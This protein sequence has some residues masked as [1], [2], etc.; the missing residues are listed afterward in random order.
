MQVRGE[1][2]AFA[3]R[4]LKFDGRIPARVHLHGELLGL[5]S[6]L[7]S[8]GVKQGIWFDLDTM[9]PLMG[10]PAFKQA[11]TVFVELASLMP[12]TEDKATCMT[13]NTPFLTGQCAMTISWSY[14]FKVTPRHAG[15]HALALGTLDIPAHH[16]TCQIMSGHTSAEPTASF[17]L[18]S[19]RTKSCQAV[20]WTPGQHATCYSVAPDC[21]RSC[22]ASSTA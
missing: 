13:Y 9:L 7:Q 4:G 11:M 12:P 16:A 10:T 22:L 5:A 1:S 17:H 6:H 15:H 21:G 20:L 2:V 18:L 19:N 3:Q 14:Y 8:Q